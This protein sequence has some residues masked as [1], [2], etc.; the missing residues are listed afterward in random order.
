MKYNV[1]IIDSGSGGLSVL[2]TIR[3]QSPELNLHYYADSGFSPYGEK[4][5]EFLKSRLVQIGRYLEALSEPVHAIVLACNTATVEGIDALRRAVS[6]PVVGVEPAVKPAL[7]NPNVSRVSVLATPV[8]IG[9]NRLQALISL[10]KNDKQVQLI[11]SA[12]LARLIDSADSRS[13]SALCKEIER[14]CSEVTV[15]RPDVLVLACTHYPLVRDRFEG[16]LHGVEILEPS[17]SVSNQLIRRLEQEICIDCISDEGLPIGG[18]TLHSSGDEGDLK[19][20]HRWCDDQSA[21]MG[22]CHLNFHTTVL[23]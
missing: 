9:S 2:N 22:K 15:F 13:E 18:V 19:S 12:D 17:S 10:W 23:S 21:V 1:A 14:I 16:S 4:S 6:I 20:L 8:T 7:V 3:R 11:S 5:S